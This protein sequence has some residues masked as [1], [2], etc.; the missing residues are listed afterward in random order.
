MIL[1]LTAIVLLAVRTLGS[2]LPDFFAARENTGLKITSIP[3][4][5]DVYLDSELVGKTPFEEVNIKK[6]EVIVKLVAEDKVW[7][8]K[9]LLNPGTWTMVQRKLS[10]GS[11]TGSGE[12]LT[13]EKGSGVSIISNPAAAAVEIDGTLAG[14]TPLMTTLPEGEHT[15]V[16]KKDN[17]LSGSIKVSV[18]EGYHLTVNIDLSLT[19]ANLTSTS[20]PLPA[21]VS[22]VKVLPTPTGFLRLRDK[23]ALSGQEIGRVAPGDELL[24]LEE[25]INW[26]KVRLS[27][28][29]EGYASSAYLQ[30]ISN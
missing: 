20:L 4:Q 7:Q 11:A 29:E 28:G 22:K 25:Q 12:V 14:Q 17:F 9:V 19:E 13:L 21:A 24:L 5:A 1:L 30:I 10:S 16:V 6:K 23:P 3:D 27:G 8:G 2:Y 15:F 26:Y 18:P